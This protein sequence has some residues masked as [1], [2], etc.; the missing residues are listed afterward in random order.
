MIGKK[1]IEKYKHKKMGAVPFFLKTFHGGIHVKDY[2]ELT[3]DLPIKTL[4]IPKKVRIP[5]NQHFGKPSRPVVKVGDLVKT[6]T[7][8][9]MGEEKISSNIHAS[10]SGKVISIDR[11]PDPLGKDSLAIEIESDGKDELAPGLSCSEGINCIQEAGIVGMG[12]A[13]FPTHI[14]LQPPKDKKV[15]TVILN[16]AECEPYITCDYRLMIEEPDKI[17]E[18][19]KIIMRVLGAKNA[20]I[21]IESNKPKAIKI[22]KEKAGWVKIIPLKTKY[23]QGGEKQLIKAILKKEVPSFGLPFDV[24]VVVQ[25]VAT[26]AAVYEAVVLHKPLYERVVTISG[27][28]VKEPG[29]YK[30]RIGTL[31][32]DIVELKDTPGKLIMGGPM[33]GL[34]QYTFNVPV[35]K[36][37]NAI[38]VMKKEEVRGPKPCIR[39]GRCILDCPMGLW[40]GRLADLGEKG[41]IDE[42]IEL[43]VKDCIECGICS[44]TCPSIRN[45]IQLVKH[46]KQS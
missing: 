2:K 5:V 22:M 37:T 9:A 13:M 30:V 8:I 10:I 11:Y 17:L 19:L 25:N 20:Y 29:N 7:V 46:A 31:F 3:K 16:G 23:P 39:C 45:I 42:A 15:D 36:S 38:L 43:G 44:Y 21:G 24:G 4:P 6:G 12:G 33:M 1:S 14:K 34:A 26:A 40:P 27:S 35:I 28:C 32:S 18:G 41:R